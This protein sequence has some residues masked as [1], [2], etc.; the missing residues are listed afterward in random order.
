M[1][2]HKGD[3]ITVIVPGDYGKPR[4][5]VI[6]QADPYAETHASL[7]VCPLTTHLTGLRLFRIAIAPDDENGL[8]EA[9]E[10]MVDKVSSLGR[11][12]AGN[13]IGKLSMGD[14]AAVD[15]A[16]RRWL[17]LDE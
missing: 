15:G 14:R 17:A 2:L 9:S 3:V 5:A 8:K 12:R 6:V 10:V 1:I 16:L 7:T 13:P 4:P 11:V